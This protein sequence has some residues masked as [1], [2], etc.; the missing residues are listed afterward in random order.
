MGIS[1]RIEFK[2]SCQVTLSQYMAN[3]ISR[4]FR[5]RLSAILDKMLK[6]I[7]AP[8]TLS[9]WNPLTRG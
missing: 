3:Y 2:S 5:R 1:K 6:T 8:V 4:Q 7:L 9:R